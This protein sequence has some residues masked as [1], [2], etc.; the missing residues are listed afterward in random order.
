MSAT[1][2]KPQYKAWFESLADP[3]ERH[4]LDEIV[5]TDSSGGLLQVVHDMDELKKV[6]ADEWKQRFEKRRGGSEWPYGSGVW[7]M[8]EWVLPEIHSDNVVSMYEGNTI[9]SGPSATAARSGSTICG[10]SS[11]ATRTPD[12]SRISG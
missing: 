5:Y 9:S 7:C 12:P 8:K 11:A 4:P 10:S 1:N 6:S 2:D 3:S